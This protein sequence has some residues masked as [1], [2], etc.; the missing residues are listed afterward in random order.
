MANADASGVTTQSNMNRPCIVTI[1]LYISGFKRLISGA[2]IWNLNIRA[3]IPATTRK[4]SDV[5][6]YRIP[7]FL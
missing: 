1:W 4:Y 2:V 3:S 5:T 7:T 6:R